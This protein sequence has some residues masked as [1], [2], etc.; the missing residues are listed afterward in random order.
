MRNLTFADRVL[1]VNHAGENGAI[2]IYTAQIMIARL[3]A[4][5]LLPELIEF[6][7]HEETHRSIFWAELQRRGVARCRS[8]WLCAAGGF[9]LGILT[10]LFGSKAI[11]AT[12]AAVERVVL[13]HLEHQLQTL[14]GDDDAATTAIASIVSEERQH[15]EQSSSHFAGGHFW[16]AIITPVVAAS[17]E[18]VIWLGMHL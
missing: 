18:A 9:M 4:P 14:A 8:Y 13:G 2:H 3:T 12:T 6:K 1:K 16:P 5:S 17:T 15:L 10:G 11:A 7:A